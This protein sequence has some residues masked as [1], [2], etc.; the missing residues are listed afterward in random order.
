MRV[1]ELHLVL[2]LPGDKGSALDIEVARD[3]VDTLLLLFFVVIAYVMH[4]SIFLVNPDVLEVEDAPLAVFTI[5][6]KSLHIDILIQG[7]H[8]HNL[9]LAIFFRVEFEL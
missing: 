9:A 5:L 4:D 2:G 1:G 6:S 7:L 3:V 8:L